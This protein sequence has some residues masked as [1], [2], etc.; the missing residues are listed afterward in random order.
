[1]YSLVKAHIGNACPQQT[2]APV[3]TTIALQALSHIIIV[4]D[5]FVQFSHKPLFLSMSLQ[6]PSCI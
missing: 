3:F 4:K 5:T 6:S 2:L 1:M